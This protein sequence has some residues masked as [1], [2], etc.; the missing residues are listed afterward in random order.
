MAENLIAAV[1]E[2][3]EDLAFVFGKALEEAGYQVV[4]FLDGESAQEYLAKNVP[5]I[6]ILD[7]HLPKISGESLFRQ[8]RSS[9]RMARTKIFLATADSR[10]AE[11]L[12]PEA[13]LVLLKPVSY[14]QLK[15]LALRYKNAAGE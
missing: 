1:I 2:D 13:D 10:L 6:V 12:Q 5:D 9:K 14:T 11:A 15:E 4:S 3:N 8:I 7:L